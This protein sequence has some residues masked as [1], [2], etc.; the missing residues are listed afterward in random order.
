[1]TTSYYITPVYGAGKPP[2]FN[3]FRSPLFSLGKRIK[4]VATAYH[5]DVV[6]RWCMVQV[7]ADEAGHDA[8]MGY[9]GVV[10]VDGPDAV[11]P[12]GWME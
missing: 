4:I 3:P 8:A 10:E 2:L 9:F 1:M 11:P 7:E 6:P 5:T 12:Q